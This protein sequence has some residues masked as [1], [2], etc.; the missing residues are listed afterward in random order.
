[1]N[2]VKTTKGRVRNKL[3]CSLDPHDAAARYLVQ[4]RLLL[5]E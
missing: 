3:W 5:P 1:M 4:R 2:G